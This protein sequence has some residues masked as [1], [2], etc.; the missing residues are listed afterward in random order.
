MQL[1]VR[2]FASTAAGTV[3]A[4][5]P[6]TISNAIPRR[7]K[8]IWPIEKNLMPDAAM[9]GA[10]YSPW[11]V[12]CRLP[13]MLNSTAIPKSTERV[14]TTQAASAQCLEKASRSFENRTVAVTTP[15]ATVINCLVESDKKS[16]DSFRQSCLA[17]SVMVG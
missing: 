13:L 14:R 11:A 16:N 17:V 6:K 2:G 7:K 9:L 3:V 4:K 12:L 5:H 8:E 15:V 1:T 10:G